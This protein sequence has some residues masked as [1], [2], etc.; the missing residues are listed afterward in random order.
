MLIHADG[1]HKRCH[2]FVA[3]GKIRRLGDCEH[4]MKNTTMELDDVDAE[5]DGETG[6]S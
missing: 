4:D 5:W 6:E 3:D 2:S 1:H